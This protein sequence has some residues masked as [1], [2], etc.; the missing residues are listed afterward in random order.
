MFKT[1]RNWI[2]S[3]RRWHDQR[4]PKNV[5]PLDRHKRRGALD[6]LDS[7]ERMVEASESIVTVCLCG[8]EYTL[9]QFRDLAFVGYQTFSDD[10]EPETI[11][12]RNCDCGSTKGIPLNKKGDLYEPDDT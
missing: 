5:I 2:E 6:E 8:N 10:V 12:M 4:L 7:L 9:K 1:L 3:R 11:E